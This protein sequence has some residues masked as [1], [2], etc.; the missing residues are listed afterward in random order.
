MWL[1]DPCPCGCTRLDLD[2]VWNLRH[3]S[4]RVLEPAF[5]LGL[6]VLVD[7]ADR[8]VLSEEG[9]ELSVRPEECIDA[10]IL[11]GA[12]KLDEE[13]DVSGE[14]CIG[15]VGR[16]DE[17]ACLLGPPPGL[18]DEHLGVQLTEQAVGLGVRARGPVAVV[19]PRH[20]VDDSGLES[21]ERGGVEAVELLCA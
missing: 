16:P 6:R 5:L 21:L 7:A 19:D 20:G 1:V 3:C 4:Q 12:A 11:P 13:L 14:G 8:F 2:P 15:G 18:D 10:E 17:H 9:R